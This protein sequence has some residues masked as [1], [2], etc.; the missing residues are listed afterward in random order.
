MSRGLLYEISPAGAAS[1]VAEPGGNPTGLAEDQA[2]R[3]WIAQ[4]GGHSRTSSKR[5]VGPGIQCLRGEAVIDVLGTGLDAPNDCAVDG[6]GAVWFTDPRGSAL[7]RSGPPGRVLRLDPDTGEVKVAAEGIHYPNGL[8]FAPGG[9]VLYVA[10]TRSSRILRFEVADDRLVGRKVIATLAGAHPDGLAIDREGRLFVAAP[11]VAAVFVLGADGSTSE[12]LRL[13]PGS[14]P[15][16]LCF[17]GPTMSTLFVTAA[18][19]GRVV[20]LELG[21][22]GLRLPP[23]HTPA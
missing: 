3:I 23:R 15:T 20:S 6:D 11:P 4:G 19:G 21:V 5:A 8:A 10:E 18:K 22:R 2:G 12:V 1:V 9:D 13:A 17:G 16:N 7:G 14:L